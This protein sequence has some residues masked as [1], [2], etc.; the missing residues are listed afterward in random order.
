MASDSGKGAG[1]LF[2][3]GFLGLFVLIWL[4]TGGPSR[5]GSW[6]SPFLTSP[7]APSAG[8]LYAFP[9]APLLIGNETDE[10][11]SA[12]NTQQEAADA[13]VY[14]EL[15]PYRG[16]IEIDQV[17]LGPVVDEKARDDRKERDEMQEYVVLTVTDR[18]NA[19]IDI[20]GFALA[21]GKYKERTLIPY[22]VETLLIGQTQS[23]ERIIARPGD[24]IIVVSGKSPAGSSFRE[25]I[26]TGYLA[27]YQK[28]TPS[29]SGS[30]PGG[31]K[32]FERFYTGPSLDANL[33]RD[34]V[35]SIQSCQYDS[36]VPRQLP[37]ACKQFVDQYL[38]HN[39]CVAAHKNDSDF[40]GDTWR[41]YLG[42]PRTLYADTYE[43]VRLLD[44]SGRVVD[45]YAY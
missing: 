30:C 42:K 12:Q 7:T 44:A 31:G 8:E 13:A 9:R 22:G 35:S 17:R 14:G 4:S 37:A 5:P 27:Q 43:T 40:S 10:Q 6:T 16:Q 21:S 23:A 38:H 26:C 24:R 41:V 15:S 18:A 29:L 34:H 19:S 2:F 36:Y 11:G 33:C 3:L 1:P 25:N 39:G 32:E 45:V 28:F 20:T